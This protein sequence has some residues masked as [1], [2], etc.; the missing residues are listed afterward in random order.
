MKL[1]VAFREQLEGLSSILVQELDRAYSVIRATWN[2]E[3]RADGSHGPVVADSYTER[4]R[5]AA[6]GAW[7]DV[8][9]SEVAFSASGSMTWT[10]QAADVEA[11]SYMRV[12]TTMLLSFYLVSTAVGGVVDTELWMTI[13]EGLRARER[14]AN[15][16]AINDA[17][18]AGMGYISVSTATPTILRI[19]KSDGS[20]WT[21]GAA[22]VYGQ[23]ALDVFE[24]V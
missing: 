21:A 6:V 15:A 3:H 20:N 12:G 18:T 23:I 4:G 1:G 24:D 9:P 7:V 5:S 14:A 13:P 22:E 2:V 17:G 8:P 16:I 19:R 10:V 11:L